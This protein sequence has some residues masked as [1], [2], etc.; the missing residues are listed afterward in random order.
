MNDSAVLGPVRAMEG[1]RIPAAN[2]IG[3]GINGTDCIYEFRKP[4]PTGFFGSILL[5][6]NKHGYDTTVAVYKW[7]TEGV[8]PPLVTVVEKGTL[9]TRDNY[10]QVYKEQ[11]LKLPD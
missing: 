1:R 2:I 5:S 4:E 6:P 10:E 9:I 7:V 3:I 8:E 11:G